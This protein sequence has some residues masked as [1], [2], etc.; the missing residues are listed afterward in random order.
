MQK[1]GDS[2]LTP[3]TVKLGGNP[4]A[5]DPLGLGKLVHA[6]RSVFVSALSY[7]TTMNFNTSEVR[8]RMSTHCQQ[9]H[10]YRS[11]AVKIYLKKKSS[12]SDT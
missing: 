11:K 1:F 2:R 10:L 8:T 9:V 7:P 6:P 4:K 12:A 3:R 5:V